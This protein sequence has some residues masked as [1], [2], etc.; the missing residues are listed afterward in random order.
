MGKKQYRKEA[1][2]NFL[3]QYL[4]QN[5]SSRNDATA[6]RFSPVQRLRER[7][8]SGNFNYADAAIAKSE[9]ESAEKRRKEQ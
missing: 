8:K 2:D 3:E 6:T 5:E 1:G 9:A 7:S 4:R